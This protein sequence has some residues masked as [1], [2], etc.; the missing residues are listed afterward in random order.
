MIH[1]N[2]KLAAL[3]SE[4]EARVIELDSVHE[5]YV[6]AMNARRA[7]GHVHV[8]QAGGRYLSVKRTQWQNTSVG[9]Q[10]HV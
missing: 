1:R 8:R 4:R 2:S 3:L 7:I 6:N 9:S 10:Y 5:R